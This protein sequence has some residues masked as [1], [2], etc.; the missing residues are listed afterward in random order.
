MAS[1]TPG[2]LL[3]LLQTMN[4]NVKVRGEYR[5]VL[6]QVISIVPALSGSELWPNHGFFIK[7]SDSSHS[8][9]V[10]LTNEDNELILTNKLGL[11]QFFYVDK[12]ESGTPVPVLA[13]VRPIP[14]RHPFVGNPKDL[15]QMLVPSEGSVQRKPNHKKDDASSKLRETV[16]AKEEKSSRHHQ[17]I[18]IKEEKTGVASRYMQGVSNPKA[19]G[20]DTSSGGSSS[21][22][23]EGDNGAG[24]AKGLGGSVKGKQQELRGQARPAGPARSRPEPVKAES[25]EP[26]ARE[27]A[28]RSK[29]MLL[30]RPTSKQENRSI[31]SRPD[32]VGRNGDASE[33]VSWSSLPVTLSKLGKGML[34]RRNLAALIAAEA[35][36]EALAA[37]HLVRCLSMFAELSSVASPEDPHTYL[38]KF[39]MLQNCIDQSHATTSTREK[40]LQLSSPTEPENRSKKTKQVSSKTTAK[41]SKSP[42]VLTEAEKL[43][44]VQGNGTEDT[45]ELRNTISFETR[46]WFLRFLE[47]AIDA[48]SR[49]KALENKGKARGG[50]VPEPDNHIAETLSQLK[51]A[52]EW[53]ERVKTDLNPKDNALAETIERLKKK[54]YSCLLLYV[55][56]AASV[57]ENRN[58]RD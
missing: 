18:V 19:S 4:S 51:Q 1:L 46:S 9:Y 27:A 23:T 43:E 49:D 16:K 39:F 26:K 24:P 32:C 47:E 31:S 6:L 50:R 22:S 25:T 54:M 5:S 20:S 44:W 55:D 56:S 34:R 40:P 3:K 28:A 48:R 21:S 30:K 45:K 15:M 53:L 8:T 52:N 41:N 42:T 37:S 57:L 7:V 38:S 17:P 10:S 14:G 58:A 12:L 13:G 2:V 11:G 29:A 36:R 33:A 35:Q